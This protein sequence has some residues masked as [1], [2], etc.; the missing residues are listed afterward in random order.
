MSSEVETSLTVISPGSIRDSSTT[1]GMTTRGAA[2]SQLIFWL[3]LGTVAGLNV[4]NADAEIPW[5]EANIRLQHENARLQKQPNGRQKTYFVLCTLYYTPMETGFTAA[6]G[7][8]V[9]KE[10][11]P[12]LEGRK[13][14]RDFL[15][16]V[17][18]EGIGR[19][20]EPVGNCSYIR[21]KE[22]RIYNFVAQPVDRNAVPLVARSSVAIR[23]GQ[24]AFGPGDELLISDRSV[25]ETFRNNRWRIVDTGRGLHRWQVDLYWGEDEPRGPGVLLARP[26]GAAFEYAYSEVKVRIKDKGANYSLGEP[27]KGQPAN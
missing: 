22:G 19:I 23:R 16:A 25:R 24:E 27:H 5:K 17:K 12:G 13:Y 21:Y 8:D 20:K 15:L 18:K 6:R 3:V 2:F 26:R 14:P 11:R 10:T 1:I 4:R 9:R 7:F